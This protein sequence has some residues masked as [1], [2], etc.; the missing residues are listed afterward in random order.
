MIKDNFM[1]DDSKKLDILMRIYH[2]VSLKDLRE[3]EKSLLPKKRK[4]M[5]PQK[6]QI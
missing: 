1:D 4:K 5:A 3:I 6:T 2:N